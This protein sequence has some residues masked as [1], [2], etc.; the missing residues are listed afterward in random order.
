VKELQAE[1]AAIEELMST[2]NLTKEEC[3]SAKQARMGL[4]VRVAEL[5]EQRD[6]TIPMVLSLND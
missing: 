1:R 3:D 6:G 2:L 5:E 4:E